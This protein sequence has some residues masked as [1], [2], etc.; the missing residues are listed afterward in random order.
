MQQLCS[1]IYPKPHRPV[2]ILQLGDGNILRGLADW[3]IQDMND[4]GAICCSVAAVQLS[5]RGRAASLALQN[6]LY[7]LRSEG[8]CGGQK[9][10]TS[11][12]I[13]VI[14]DVI[15]PAKNYIH[16]LSYAARGELAM[17][18]TNGTE[19]PC[20]FDIEDTDFTRCP[21]SFA[22]LLL[23]L[24]KRRY[25][26]FG[27]D[28]GKGL[29]IVPCDLI[30]DNGRELKD[31]LVRLA[32]AANLGGGFIEWLQTANR[33]V[34]TLI[35]RIVP[36]YPAGEA[37]EVFAECGYRDDN[38]VKSELYYQLVLGDPS[39]RGVFPAD[40]TGANVV[41]AQDVAPYAARKMRLLNGSHTALAAAAHLCGVST[42]GEAAHDP[43]LY[44]FVR[45]YAVNEACPTIADLSGGSTADYAES[46]LERFKNPYIRHEIKSILQGGAAKYR[47]RILPVIKD[48]VRT[49][50]KLP[51]RSVF[52]LAALCVVCGNKEGG[53]CPNE[54]R[55]AEL[56]GAIAGGGDPVVLAREILA[57]RETWGCDL[58]AVHPS[59][60]RLVGGYIA[61]IC[62]L[63]GRGALKKLSGAK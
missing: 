12:V 47:M 7:T 18:L 5:P 55:F 10:K 54:A 27:G 58:N 22:G 28:A 3:M 43:L 9:V 52:A 17:V 2:R 23:A 39:L 20:I 41:F 29:I 26:V 13:D 15:D 32:R 51:A 6:G 33:F 59:F 61:D 24:L 37:E 46:V 40:K 38:V 35:D 36:G 30:N 19:S 25:E 49:A 57:D 56:C 62:S 34:S 14:D 60:S 31:R 63:G 44:S 50:G 21:H 53:I 48:Y 11:R 8:I 45:E 42:V 4:H 1:K 16:Y